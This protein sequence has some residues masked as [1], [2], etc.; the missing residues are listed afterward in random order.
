MTQTEMTALAIPVQQVRPDPKQPRH[1]L[2]PDLCQSLADG[3]A[4]FEILDQLRERGTRDKWI[5]ERLA[6]LD[7]LADSIAA[8]GLIQP[9]RVF[10]DAEDRYR[11]E[12]GERRWWA[13]QIL[14]GRGDTRFKTIAAF[15]IPQAVEDTALL[16]RRVAENVFRS[17]FTAIEMARAMAARKQ[18]I[19]ASE[20]ALSRRE[21]ETRVGKENGMSDRRV[22]QFL[23]LVKL[24]SDVQ[25]IAQRA[26]LGESQ[27]R[28]LVGI[29][30]PAR[31]MAAAQAL[32]HP[33]QK[34]PR[35][36][37]RSTSGK[38]STR[39]PR[40][41]QRPEKASKKR[42]DFDV[43]GLIGLAKG[44]Q[45]RNVERVAQ[46]LR[47]RVSEDEAERKAIACLRDVLDR[48]LSGTANS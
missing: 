7:A 28:I 8:D 41:P 30:D 19:I 11:I 23:A 45:S 24:P 37:E 25:E 3:S 12:A 34:K 44:L 26:R 13:H 36:Q 18:E 33:V 22:R 6:E 35:Q 14:L 1:L 20:P 15:V 21:V 46:E 40:R 38:R 10:Q 39:T 47:S 17:D 31:Q 42:K 5:R 32:I 16:R 43:S 4:P 9:I 27:L 2:P 48:G 29:K